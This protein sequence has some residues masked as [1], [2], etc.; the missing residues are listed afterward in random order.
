MRP[1]K[2]DAEE[3]DEQL[4]RVPHRIDKVSLLGLLD[5]GEGLRGDRF[6]CSLRFV[7]SQPFQVGPS[8]HAQEVGSLTGEIV[9]LADEFGDVVGLES[10]LLYTSDAADE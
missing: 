3:H 9:E 5:R 10:C 1:G 2:S 6:A 7:E 4:E 8:D